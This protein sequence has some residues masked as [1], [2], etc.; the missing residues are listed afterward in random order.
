MN[1]AEQPALRQDD[2]FVSG[3]D[4][5]HTYR[6]PALL[7]TAKG[8]LLAFCEGR[9]GGQGDSGDIDLVLKRSLDGGATWLPLQVVWD[10]G[11]NTAG[12]PC[13]VLDRSTGTIWLPL[14]RNLGQD[15]E[16]QIMAGTSKGTRTVWIT[17]STDDGATWSE[18]VEI[19]QT[20]KDPSWTWYA[21]GPGC[22]IQM[23][24]GRLVIPCDHAVATTKAWRSH[25]IYSDDHGATWK[26]GGAT[27][28]KCNE[29]Q[30][31]ELAG[32]SLLLNMRS[33]HG[34]KCRAVAT[35]TDGGL[36]WSDVTS[37]AALVEPVC[38]ASFLRYTLEKDH[39]KNRL[40]FANPA[41]AKREKMTVR[42][43]Y[44]EGKT[45]PVSKLVNAG[46]SAYSALAVLPDMTI[47]CLYERGEKSAYE[48]IALA[49][50]SLEW[51]T[52][53]KDK[54]K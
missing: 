21:T 5:Y 26:L 32:G 36:T 24:S 14:T 49:R 44:D 25:V 41:S 54:L 42:L 45:W 33:Y 11:P 16:S 30:V 38:Q 7:V 43:S 27:A 23:Q 40:L 46:P 48:K 28:E 9:K 6:I 52:E 1:S 31:V 17:K 29:C 8:T 22:G 35:S 53:G 19:T 12:N 2:V 37:D 13:P 15:S 4:G 20:T 34:R 3:Q 50:F 10:D 18:P 47:A 51:L 39:G